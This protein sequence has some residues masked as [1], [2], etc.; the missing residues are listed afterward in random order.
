MGLA[1]RQIVKSD[2][3]K[4]LNPLG[5]EQDPFTILVL[6]LNTLLKYRMHPERK[7]MLPVYGCQCNLSARTIKV[8]GCLDVRQISPKAYTMDGLQCEACGCSDN[9]KVEYLPDEFYVRV[10]G[11]DGEFGDTGKVE[12]PYYKDYFLNGAIQYNQK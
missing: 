6:T 8:A 7:D 10:L 4:V 2:T 9:T 3:D 5:E 12:P 1:V 11:C